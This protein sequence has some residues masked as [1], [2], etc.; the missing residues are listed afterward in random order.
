MHYF[1]EALLTPPESRLHSR[2]STLRLHNDRSPVSS[3]DL[4]DDEADDIFEMA[5]R[6]YNLDI[7][8]DED[9]TK[10]WT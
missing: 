4:N 1:T 2:N 5:R 6:K 7:S 10:T 8:D 3:L 9:D